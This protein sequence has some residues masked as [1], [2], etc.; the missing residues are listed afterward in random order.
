MKQLPMCRARRRQRWLSSVSLDA[1]AVGAKSMIHSGPFGSC[2]AEL[3]DA[4]KAPPN[5]TFRIEDSGVLYFT[6]GYIETK[7][8]PGRFDQAVIFCPFCGKQLQSK[9]EIAAKSSTR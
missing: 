6:V 9:E 1:E 3:E 2:C 7:Q 4:M 8:G 5:S